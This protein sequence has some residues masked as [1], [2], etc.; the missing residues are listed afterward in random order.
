MRTPHERLRT[1]RERAGYLTTTAAAKALGVTLSTY[2]HHENGTRQFRAP[3]AVRY[4][5]FF[6]VSVSWLLTGKGPIDG[7]STVEELYE[8]LPDDAKREALTYL[9]YL[10]SR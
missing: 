4:A 10:A 1:A 6:R 5:T 3:E 8:S 9:E 2:T 7:R